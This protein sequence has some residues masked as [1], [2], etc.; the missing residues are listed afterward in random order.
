MPRGVRLRRR[1]TIRAAL[2]RGFS[3]ET[4]EGRLQCD[5]LTIDFNRHHV[6][7]GSKEIHLTPKEF[8]LLSYF[9]RHPNRLLTH[10]AILAAVWGREAVDRPQ[11]LWALVRQLRKKLEVDPSHPRYL[12]SEPWIGYRFATTAGEQ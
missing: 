5:G 8:E 10:S 4:A 12:V 6:L 7:R 3:A 11:H 2:R 9:A 1:A